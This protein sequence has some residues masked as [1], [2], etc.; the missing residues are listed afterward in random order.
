MAALGATPVV[1]R[2][3]GVAARTVEGGDRRAIA[4]VTRSGWV[5]MVA[6]GMNAADAAPAPEPHMAL[7]R[8]IGNASRSMFAPLAL[9]ATAWSAACS[10]GSTDPVGESGQRLAL[11]T[12]TTWVHQEEAPRTEPLLSAGPIVAD[13]L[14]LA[15]DQTGRWSITYMDVLDGA[16]RHH[17]LIDVHWRMLAAGDSIVVSPTCGPPTSLCDPLPPWVGT[18]SPAG[19]L[20]LVSTVQHPDDRPRAYAR[21]AQ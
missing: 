4:R 9:L 15:A 8:R 11:A 16:T 10:S 13:T 1:P 19:M 5:A 3:P 17:N 20:V 14:R 6:A 18:I 7:A 21:V 2:S 12:A